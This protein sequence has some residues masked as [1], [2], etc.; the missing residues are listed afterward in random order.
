MT[1]SVIAET[2]AGKVRGKEDKGVLVFKG[3]PYGASTGGSRRFLPPLPPEPWKGIR[4][5]LAYGPICPQTGLNEPGSVTVFGEVKNYAMGED[6]L[7]MNIWTPALADGKKRPVMFWLHGGGFAQG[8][9]AGASYNGTSLVKRGDVVVVTINHRLNV[10]GHLYLDEIGGKKYAGSGNAGLLDIVQALKWTRENIKAFGGDPDRVMIFGESGGGRKVSVLLTMPPAK[11]LFHRAVIESSPQLRASSPKAATAMT[12]HVLAKLGIRTNEIEKLQTLPFE[13]LMDTL[14]NLTREIIATRDPLVRGSVGGF[15]AP[16]VDGSSLPANPFYPVTS[17]TLNDVP[18]MIGTNRD[19][20]AIGLAENPRRLQFTVAN[21][22]ESL[23]PML[24]D[25]VDH[26]IGIYKKTRP[27]DTPWDLFIGISSE[28]RRL[29]C[30]ELVERKLAKGKA[31][32]FMYLFTW[33]TDFHGGLY[34]ACHALEIPFVFDNINSIPITGNR[35]DK[36][37]LASSMSEA[38]INFARSGDPNHSGIPNWRPY[39]TENRATMILDVPCK[40]VVDPAR[41]E[42]DAWKGIEVVA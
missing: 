35:P 10:M 4:D 34:K 11:G 38:W 27:N 31:P 6:C 37:L 41:E 22:R 16:V 3:I 5:T 1:N 25:K 18:I 12:E 32:V 2:T 7:V 21:L 33:N 42:L 15:F 17:S 28:D 9:G 19:E 39:T 8:S 24:G 14:N 40:A 29:G 23:K 26:V 36:P 13:Q 30:I 20:K